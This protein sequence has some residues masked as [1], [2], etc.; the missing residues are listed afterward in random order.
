MKAGGN[1]KSFEEH[2]DTSELCGWS[3]LLGLCFGN[4]LSRKGWEFGCMAAYSI[5]ALASLLRLLDF[6]LWCACFE[7]LNS[8]LGLE[9]PVF[10][11]YGTPV[12]SYCPLPSDKTG[13]EPLIFI[14]LKLEGKDVDLK[15][16]KWQHEYLISSCPYVFI[17]PVI[18]VINKKW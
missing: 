17:K 14:A 7:T 4:I 8:I 11:G 13:T 18:P 16:S 12:F 10:F 5:F 2:L 15:Q 6:A 3:C 1:D 9:M